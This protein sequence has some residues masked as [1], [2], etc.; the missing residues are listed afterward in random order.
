VKRAISHF[1]IPDCQVKAG[2]NTAHMDWIG[3]YIVERKPDVVVNLGDF[4]DM[5]SL[6]SYDSGKKAFEGRRYIKDVDTGKEA[7]SRLVAPLKGLKKRPRLVYLIGNH[8][9][10]IERAIN[11]DSKLDGTI[12]YKDLDLEHFGWEVHPF[13]EIVEIGGI[14]YSHFFPRS[15]T[16]QVSQTKK[17]APSAR[18]QLIR[19]GGSATAGHTQGLDIA[20]MP[21][22]GRLQYGL[23]AGSCYL[24]D[25]EYMSPQGNTHWR[26]VV[27]KHQVENGTY[28]PMM[29]SLDYLKRR[30]G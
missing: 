23:I 19:E 4:F 30:Y 26:G 18:A 22:K 17:G 27:C 2:V 14:S 25:E 3:K 11:D 10:R 8:E 24:H 13:L 16:G 6:S 5:P 9:Y 20:C 1:V 29:V 21:L 28:D 7:M 12:G 15:A